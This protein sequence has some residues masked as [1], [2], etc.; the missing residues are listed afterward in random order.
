MRPSRSG[1]FGLRSGVAIGLLGLLAAGCVK[2]GSDPVE[3]APSP[4]Q[5][6]L[7][8]REMPALP[9]MAG[10]VPGAYRQ[11]QHPPLEFEGVDPLLNSSVASDPWM[12]ERID[13]WTEFW[14]TRGGDHF[15]RYIHRMG[16]YRDLVERELEDRGLPPSLRYLPVVESGYHPSV[17]SRAGATGLW[18]IMQGTATHL[19]LE[20]SSVVDERRDP[21]HATRAAANYLQELYL[22]F[23]SW[24]LALAAY[25][26]GPGRISGILDRHGPDD[27]SLTGDEVYVLV[28]AHLP[29]ETREFVPRFFA[30]ARIASDP[31]AWGFEPHGAASIL[32]FDEV[33][34]PD[35][36]SLEVVARAAGTDEEEI[37]RLNPQFIRGF[38]PAG[39]PAVVRVPAGQAQAFQVAFAQIPPEERVTFVEHV[40][41]SGDTPSHI[42]QRYGVSVSDLSDANGGIDPR[43]L[44]VGQRL[45]VPMGGA[46]TRSARTAPTQTAAA[47]TGAN[48]SAAPPAGPAAEGGNGVARSYTVRGGDSLWSIARRFGVTVDDLRAWNGLGSSTGIRPGQEL[49]VSRAS[50]ASVHRVRSGDTWGGIAGRFGISSSELARVNGRT[51]S[52]VIRVGEELVIPN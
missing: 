3:T 39:R 47:S 13:H 30:A 46:D 20:A 38:T 45:V 37:L 24:F 2:V 11:I 9:G 52:D 6:P 7:P 19:G 4:T 42:A 8:V 14:T 28:R 33:E 5:G 10:G 16:E 44:Q 51:T 1:G 43:R 48:A 36:T 25:N 35:A 12:Q 23:D 34:V 22:I 27:D 31:E 29:A 40:V 26:A 50:A 18:Q 49:A 41:A 15:Q 17:V 32:A 21:V